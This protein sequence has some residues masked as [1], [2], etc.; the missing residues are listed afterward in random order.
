MTDRDNQ[1]AGIEAAAK[2]P[3]KEAL[4]RVRNDI[5]AG[6]ILGYGHPSGMADVHLGQEVSLAIGAAITAYLAAEPQQTEPVKKWPDIMPGYI[7]M[8]EDIE[9]K[10]KKLAGIILEV[11]GVDEKAYPACNIW[12]AI[13]SY[14]HVDRLDQA[15]LVSQPTPTS[16]ADLINRPTWE[17]AI[18]IVED[19]ALDAL[20]DSEYRLAC[21]DLIERFRENSQANEAGFGN[22]AINNGEPR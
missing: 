16:Q 7:P 6:A 11:L 22:T 20:P 19:Y 4:D 5:A 8:P 10:A 13:A 21:N 9:W 1:T 18:A 3:V 15:A 14:I 17:A 2:K 12:I